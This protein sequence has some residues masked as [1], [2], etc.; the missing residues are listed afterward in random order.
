M[1]TKYKIPKKNYVESKTK[2]DKYRQISKN[3]FFFK[4]M[5]NAREDSEATGIGYLAIK[6]T[7]INGNVLE[8]P[9]V[10][11]NSDKLSDAFSDSSDEP[12]NLNFLTPRVPKRNLEKK[13]SR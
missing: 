2:Q 4:D 3:D 5:T 6:S 7:E 11:I 8:I 1:S 9:Q 12:E 10:V 13:G